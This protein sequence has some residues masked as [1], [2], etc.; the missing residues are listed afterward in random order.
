VVGSEP[1]SNAGKAGVPLAE[2]ISCCASY[3]RRFSP[4]AL[5]AAYIGA[6]RLVLGDCR[7]RCLWEWMTLVVGPN[8][9]L[10]VLSCAAAV[11]LPIFLPGSV[12]Q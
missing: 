4:L 1:I 6:C 10:L 2:S 5:V 11:Q 7:P 8:Y 3:R 9:R 12:D